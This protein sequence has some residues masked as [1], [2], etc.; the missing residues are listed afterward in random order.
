[1][2]F[3][4]LFFILS[5]F[6]AMARIQDTKNAFDILLIGSSNFYKVVASDGSFEF[7]RDHS[8]VI[9]KDGFVV[10]ANGDKLAPGF[11]LPKN[12]TGAEVTRG[13]LV[14]I[15]IDHNPIPTSLGEIEVYQRNSDQSFTDITHLKSEFDIQQGRVYIKD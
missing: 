6:S 9:Q 7:T 8:F 3:I 11:Q 5:S 15:N 12:A 4:F 10:N 14:K 1:M 13:G 2:K